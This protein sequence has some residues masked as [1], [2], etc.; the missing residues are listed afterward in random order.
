MKILIA[1]D[2]R[3]LQH[4]IKTFLE[5]DGN[6]CETASDFQ[7]TNYKVSLYDYDIILLDLNLIDGNGLDILKKL[8]KDK[9]NAAVLI[10][11]ANNSLEDKLMGLILVPMI[12]LLNLFTWPNSIP[13]SK[14]F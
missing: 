13:A 9:K 6:V 4:S 14:Q 10:I 12:T 1:E 3:S 2:E 5:K 7:E 11:S 8:K